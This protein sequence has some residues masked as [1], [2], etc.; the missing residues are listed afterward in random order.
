M[1][2]YDP[3]L[4]DS[5]DEGIFS[6]DIQNDNDMWEAIRSEIRLI[7]P[8]GIIWKQRHH[9]FNYVSDMG[10]IKKLNINNRS[11]NDQELFKYLWE[12]KHFE[13]R[14]II[15]I[16]HEHQQSNDNYNSDYSE[17][18]EEDEESSDLSDEYYY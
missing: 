3:V 15:D 13:R 14:P 7:T 5:D 6:K 2:A 11:K 18:S 17:L 1:N 16:I 8:F 4:F 9:V 10:T 12:R